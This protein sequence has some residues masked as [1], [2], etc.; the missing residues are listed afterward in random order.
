MTAKVIA[1]E[2]NSFKKKNGFRPSETLKASESE[3]LDLFLIS[4]PP[5]LIISLSHRIG[6]AI[7]HRNDL[8]TIPITKNKVL[9]WVKNR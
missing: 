5:I 8:L 7:P 9:I 3:N 6:P 4:V 1:K 2:N